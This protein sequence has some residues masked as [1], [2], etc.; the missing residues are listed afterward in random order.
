MNDIRSAFWVGLLVTAAILG[1][2]F[3]FR[4]F[5]VCVYTHAMYDVYYFLSHHRP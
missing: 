4:G 1:F 5:G 2:L 3:W